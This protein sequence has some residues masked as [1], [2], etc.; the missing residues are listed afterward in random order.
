MTRIYLVLF[1]LLFT[2]ALEAQVSKVVTGNMI[3]QKTE[4]PIEKVELMLKNT[5]TK[6]EYLAETDD[7]GK[8][9]FK[10][11]PFGKYEFH[12]SD[13]DYMDNS[14]KVES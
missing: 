10:N 8:F 1:T 12:V 13:R 11:I 7:N 9:I 6:S 2:F 14:F 3:D 4:D 5:A